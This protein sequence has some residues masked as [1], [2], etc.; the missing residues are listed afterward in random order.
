MHDDIESCLKDPI[1]YFFDGRYPTR[2]KTELD[3][4]MEQ[5]V[6]VIAPLSSLCLDGAYSF[7]K[8]SRVLNEKPQLIS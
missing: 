7:K 2:Y 8:C 4:L 6:E 3:A 5:I 1:I